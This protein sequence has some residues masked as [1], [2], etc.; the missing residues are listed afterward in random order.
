MTARDAVGRASASN[1][2]QKGNG[3]K[4]EGT[5]GQAGVCTEGQRL[6]ATFFVHGVSGEPFRAVSKRTECVSRS[7]F[8]NGLSEG[9]SDFPVCTDAEF[10]GM[11]IRPGGQR[12]STFPASSPFR[13]SILEKCRFRSLLNRW[14][15]SCQSGGFRIDFEFDQ[16][17]LGRQFHRVHF[18]RRNTCLFMLVAGYKPFLLMSGSMESI[19]DRQKTVR[20]ARVV[21]NSGRKSFELA[22]SKHLDGSVKTAAS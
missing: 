11:R 22:L 13:Q 6:T 14:R 15:R 10:P 12:L 5:F 7:V 17:A 21:E 8:L 9:G 19:P 18:F 2:L 20:P 4:Y 16:N 3:P 1:Q